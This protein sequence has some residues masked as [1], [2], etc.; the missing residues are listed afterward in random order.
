MP[1]TRSASSFPAPNDAAP[2][3]QGQPSQVQPGEGQP[4]QAQPDQARARTR[5]AIIDRLAQRIA[6]DDQA[7]ASA[8]LRGRNVSGREVLARRATRGRFG[9]ADL[10][11]IGARL[12]TR[13]TAP[14]THAGSLDA[15]EAHPGA[16]GIPSADADRGVTSRDLLAASD[17]T[18]LAAYA[19]VLACQLGAPLDQQTALG[20]F[21][22]LTSSGT[23]LAKRDAET[24]AQLLL[25]AGRLDDAV[26]A[27]RLKAVR[28]AN[29]ALTEA[30]ALN[31]H[32]RPGAPEGP[33]IAALSAALVKPGTIPI[34]LAPH[35]RTTFDRLTSAAPERAGSVRGPLVA[36]I[37]SAFNP[38]ERLITAVHSMVQQT[39]ANWELLIVDDASPE[40]TPGVLERAEAMDP[41]VRVIRKAVN[42]GTYRARNT[43]L[44]QSG[45]DF[46]TC[47]DSDDWAHPERLEK[48]LAPLLADPTLMAT[49]SMGVRAD[50]DLVITRPGYHGHLVNAPSLLVRMH[51]AVSRIGLFDTVRKAADTE[52]ALR[53]EAAFGVPIETLRADVLTMARH[54]ATSLSFGEFA[55][56]WRHEARSAYRA[57][58]GR[59]HEEIRGGAD[60]YLDPEGP[61][62]FPAPTRWQAPLHPSLAR[63]RTADVVIVDDVRTGR[64]GAAASAERIGGLREAG[65][66][67]ALLHTENLLDVAEHESPLDPVIQ[68]L[69][70]SGEV[71]RVYP[72]DDL[73]AGAVLIGNP[74]L[75]QFP[76]W[77]QRVFPAARVLVVASESDYVDRESVESGGRELFGA[78]VEFVL[79]GT[80]PA[81]IAGLLA[82]R[83]ARPGETVPE[84]DAT[85]DDDLGDLPAVSTDKVW[86]NIPTRRPGDGEH[87]DALAIRYAVDSRAGALQ[88]ARD[89][90][91]R[92]EP[93]EVASPELVAALI[94]PGVDAVAQR[95][96]GEVHQLVAPADIPTT[97]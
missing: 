51:P 43:A 25:A 95:L 16:G 78:P 48:G 11:A 94:P 18:L 56:G 97:S 29:R 58:Y 7:F 35:G 41:R 88:F 45:A 54:E 72:E 62:R 92:L 69:V 50:E 27:A 14:A 13:G 63:A 17:P 75:L 84:D 71:E 37:M 86:L 22:A 33:W 67:V 34:A 20:L 93:G 5:A 39:W 4:N 87:A 89:L 30:D 36:V 21:D 52:Y 1:R 44:R 55:P 8:L 77:A 2:M 66:E 53:L 64:A 28:P 19:Y 24:H 10:Q 32:L 42:G 40:P 9:D 59:W 60:P 81:A 12:A 68:A 82:A 65:F 3:S 49:R 57:A 15:G 74:E 76:F 90:L 83:S 47:L 61:R 73:S 85:V 38:D 26:A 31:P 46:F 79:P 70:D 6:D 80:T 23:T 91:G 96:S